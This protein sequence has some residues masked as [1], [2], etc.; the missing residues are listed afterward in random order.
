MSQ[1]KSSRPVHILPAFGHITPLL[2]LAKRLSITHRITFAVS[3]AKLA[4]LRSRQLLSAEEEKS[5]SLLSLADD[6]PPNFDQITDPVKIASGI[7]QM[8]PA[9]KE[10]IQLMPIKNQPNGYRNLEPVDFVV[11]DLCMEVPIPVCKERGVPAFTFCCPGGWA[12]GNVLAVKEDT[13]ASLKN[14]LVECSRPFNSPRDTHQFVRR[15]GTGSETSN[16]RCLPGGCGDPVYFVGP[17]F[18]EL[19]ATLEHSTLAQ[20]VTSWLDRQSDRSV[21]YVSFGSQASLVPAQIAELAKA[22]LALKKPF[23]WS[24]RSRS[25][26]ICQRSFATDWPSTRVFVSHCGWNSTLEGI[27]AGVPIVAWPMFG[28]QHANAV[29][30]AKI[31][32]GFPMRDVSSLAPRIVPGE[33]IVAAVDITATAGWDGKADGDTTYCRKVRELSRQAKEAVSKNGKSTVDFE[34]FRRSIN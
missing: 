28:D 21:V 20:Q 2:E 18:P 17:L 27:S 12:V 31:G 25:S 7:A 30:V 16:C 8:G 19:T 6:L 3:E 4:D 24:L 23:I 14:W 26:S 34:R 10:L 5:I 33:E 32:C 29:M 22:L 13:P 11:S 9:Q 15:L 1:S